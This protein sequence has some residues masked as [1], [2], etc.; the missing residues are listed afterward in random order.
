LN[1]ARPLFLI[2]R[3]KQDISAGSYSGTVRILSS[4]GSEIDQPLT[5]NVSS[6][7]WVVGGLIALGLGVAASFWLT[8]YAPFQSDRALALFPFTELQ[9]RLESAKTM[10]AGLNTPDLDQRSNDARI[11]MQPAQLIAHN[12]LLPR[13]P[14]ADGSLT[15]RAALN[16]ELD[17]LTPI[18]VAIEQISRAIQLDSGAHTAALD[19]IAAPDRS[20]PPADVPNAIS[21]AAQAVAARMA[22][23]P[24]EALPTAAAIVYRETAQNLSFWVIVS[25][26]TIVVGYVLLIAN[27]PAYGGV[28]DLLSAF[29]WGIGL[30]AAGGKLADLNPGSIRTNLRPG[31]KV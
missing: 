10:R 17:R 21:T 19:A 29:L 1:E 22:P 13:W 15:D 2:S 24:P 18:V 12:M 4:N 28:P 6:G 14:T 7:G 26:L 27:N 31:A 3:S 9:N 8:V 5:V 23:L 11:S 30:P 20:F 25:A 16:K